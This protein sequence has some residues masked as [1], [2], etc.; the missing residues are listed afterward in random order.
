MAR[1]KNT[2]MKWQ[3]TAFSRASGNPLSI[4]DHRTREEAERVARKIRR[5]GFN[6][7]VHR[8]DEEIE[9]E[10]TVQ[11]GTVTSLDQL[12]DRS[13]PSR[14]VPYSEIMACPTHRLDPAHYIPRHHTEED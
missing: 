7:E 12:A 4:T 11:M 13:F 3:V 9:T 14:S 8:A 5:D 10:P 1:K 2:T 6:A